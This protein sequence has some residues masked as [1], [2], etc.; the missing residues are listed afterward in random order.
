MTRPT[1]NVSTVGTGIVVV[2]AVIT[3]AAFALDAHWLGAIAVATTILLAALVTWRTMEALFLEDQ[4]DRDALAGAVFGY[5]LMAVLW[6]ELYPGHRVLA[7]GLFGLSEGQDLGTEMLYL[8]LVTITTLGYGDVLPLKAFPRILAGVEAAFGTLYIAVLIGRI[9]GALKGPA[10][11]KA[12]A[13]KEGLDQ[14]AD[15]GHGVNAGTGDQQN[16]V[17]YVNAIH[18]QERRKHQ[19][20]EHR[21]RN[22]AGQGDGLPQGPAENLPG[23]KQGCRRGHG[24]NHGIG[25]LKG[26]EKDHDGGQDTA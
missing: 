9:V 7:T 13:R 15:E 2:W 5:F 14:K 12:A 26:G 22:Q 11:R 17:D 10:G 18:R 21:E 16:A 8:S 25:V 6:S 24:D 4:T 19:A 23:K 3:L 1:S 20:I